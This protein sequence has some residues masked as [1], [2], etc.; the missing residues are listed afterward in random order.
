MNDKVLLSVAPVAATD[1]DVDPAAIARDVV[2]CARAGAGMVHLHVRD[3][4]GRLT[5]NLDYLRKTI[6]LIR[7]EVD[8]VIEVSTGGVSNLSIEDR[9]TSL[10][11]DQVECSSLN[12]GSVNLGKAV[13]KNPIDEVRWCVEAILKHGKTPEVEVFEIGMI[14]TALMLDKEFHFKAPLLFSIVLGHEGA[15]PAT[16]EALVAMQSFIPPDMLWGITHAHRV[17]N[18]IMCAA[19]GLGAKT[20]RIGF[21]DSTY[22]DAETI[23]TTNLPMVEH[24][25]KLLHAMGKEPMTPD[26]ARA[27]FNIGGGR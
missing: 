26:E 11:L 3:R 9:C 6:D 8:I 22:I 18:D 4:Q 23:A 17:N 14:H 2:S 16:P 5:P 20:V 15:A 21:D 27:F 24:F 7:S 12:V 10:G 19:I 25:V 1:T 13:Y